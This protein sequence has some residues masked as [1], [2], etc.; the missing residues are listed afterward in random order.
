MGSL[1]ESLQRG[2]G[3]DIASNKPTE[4]SRFVGAILLLSLCV[5]PFGWVGLAAPLVWLALHAIEVTSGWRMALAFLGA[6]SVMLISTLGLVPGGERIEWLAAYT[7]ASGNL[8]SAGFNPGKAAIAA[9]VLGFMLRSRNWLVFSD[10]RYVLVAIAV[11]SLFGLALF[12]TSPKFAATIIAALLTNFLVV[13]ISEEAFF[14][15][16]VQ[17]GGELF[18]HR[19][20][21]LVALL[22]TV[23]F[24]FLHTGWAASP[25]AL[26]VVAAAG[27]SYALLWMRT[28][29]FW[30][31]VLA[32]GGINAFHMLLLPYPL[33]G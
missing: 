6:A 1:S 17:R 10:L 20:R 7:D 29:N 33:P 5:V 11:P 27:L 16:V 15:L 26:V 28:Q 9:G 14:R 21:W 12:G 31:C 8:I 19:A 4:K 22:V 18:M 13:A 2:R 24:T 25:V 30:A 23:L 3:D 32:H